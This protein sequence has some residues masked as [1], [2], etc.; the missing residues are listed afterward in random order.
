MSDQ[1]VILLNGESQLQY[2]RGK[3]LIG[4]QRQ[5]LDKMDMEL[6]HR[7][8]FTTWKMIRVR[9]IIYMASYPKK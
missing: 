2:D 4:R 6:Q 9:K 8:N 3:P 7:D 5:F 1:L